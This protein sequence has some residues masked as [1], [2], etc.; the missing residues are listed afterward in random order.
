MFG[1]PRLAPKWLQG[2]LVGKLTLT[3][4]FR[5]MARIPK[6]SIAVIFYQIFR[7]HLNSISDSL[8]GGDLKFKVKSHLKFVKFRKF[9][10]KLRP[11]VSK[12]LFIKR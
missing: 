3:F 6:N 9:N 11:K 2:E 10:L 7:R 12:W 8:K 4:R 1:V 5:K